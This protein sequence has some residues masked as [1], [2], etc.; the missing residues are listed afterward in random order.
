M[1]DTAA[2]TTP[3]S[4]QFTVAGRASETSAVISC[5]GLGRRFAKRWALAHLE[6]EIRAGETVLL[7]GANGS[8]KTTLLRIACGLCRPS[9]GQIRVCGFDP[10]EARREVRSR[11]TLISHQSYLYAGLTARETV[12]LWREL[13][14]RSLGALGE[15]MHDVEALLE[16]VQ[17]FE[18]A[19]E[20]VSGFSQGMRKRLTL[21]RAAIEQPEVVLLDEPF[22][23]LDPAGQELVAKWIA[24]FATQGRTVVF[25][26]HTLSAARRIAGRALLLHRGQLAWDGPAP[27]LPEFASDVLGGR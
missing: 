25:A 22:A 10:F 20:P 27:A 3:S 14:A 23:A 7:A 18:S 26:S 5:S 15:A 11:V 12:T 4:T 8:G 21:L 24:D 16:S 6:L 17:L 2:N 13:A 19:D 9:R 1:S